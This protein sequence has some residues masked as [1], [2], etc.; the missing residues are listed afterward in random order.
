MAPISLI[1]Q[2]ITLILLST[3]RKIKSVLDDLCW[4]N[5]VGDLTE[6][7]I[8]EPEC[9]DIQIAHSWSC[10]WDCASEALYASLRPRSHHAARFSLHYPH[11]QLWRR[12]RDEL[13]FCFRN[14]NLHQL[15]VCRHASGADGDAHGWAFFVSSQSTMRVIAI[16]LFLLSELST[17]RIRYVHRLCCCL[18]NRRGSYLYGCRVS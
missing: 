14:S 11:V 4:F 18:S 8:A 15:L 6:N 9:F 7:D 5:S 3:D 17:R 2:N 10:L 13:A 16:V 1:I 12:K